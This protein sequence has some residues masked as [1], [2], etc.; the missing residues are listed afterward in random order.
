[1]KNLLKIE[2]PK[3]PEKWNYKNSVK[4]VKSVV[5]KWGKLT[6]ELAQ[7][8]WIAR[9]KLSIGHRPIT[10]SGANAP[11][12]WN[13]YCED[14]GKDKSTV[15][16]WLARWFNFPHISLSSGENEWYTP[17]D[18]IIAAREVMGKI[19]LDPASSNVAN[20]TVK[21][22]KYF[23]KKGNGLK[24]KWF[25]NVWMNPP[26]AQPLVDKFSEAVTDKFQSG[27]IKQACILVN[28]ATETN[29]FQ[30]MLAICSAVCFVKGRVKFL[31]E[32]GKATGMPLQGQAILYFGDNVK[33]FYKHFQE[34]G[35]I[36]WTKEEK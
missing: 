16:R 9:E 33:T 31:D 15:N 4:K 28:N 6:E 11:L 12:T 18:Y 35:L 23:T 10:I 3:L 1:M 25:G 27:E 21:A 26:Y 2:K 34:F 7:E 13:D 36:L 17:P 32:E 5:Y 29:W 30:T 19:D 24:R 8:L 20:K 14:I 22:D